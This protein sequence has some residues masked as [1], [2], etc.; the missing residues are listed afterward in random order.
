MDEPAARQIEIAPRVRPAR[1][2]RHAVIAAIRSGQPVMGAYALTHDEVCV[3]GT[4]TRAFCGVEQHRSSA[5][6]YPS[7]AEEV[8][9]CGLES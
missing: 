1:G 5:Q 9:I 8:A 4:I 7:I 6:F 3:R 2:H